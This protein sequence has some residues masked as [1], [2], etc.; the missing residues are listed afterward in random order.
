MILNQ[1]L[2]EPLAMAVTSKALGNNDWVEDNSKLNFAGNFRAQDFSS[3]LDKLYHIPLGIPP[4][5]TDQRHED[6]SIECSSSRRRVASVERLMNNDPKIPSWDLWHFTGDSDD[7]GTEL[8]TG[9]EE[10][11]NYG[12]VEVSIYNI[13]YRQCCTTRRAR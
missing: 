12:N 11:F 10:F 2:M 1:S 4:L 7:D 8:A 5:R 9:D 3:F 13:R 6:L